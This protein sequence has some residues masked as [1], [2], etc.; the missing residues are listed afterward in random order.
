VASVCGHH[1]PAV[2]GHAQHFERLRDRVEQPG[3]RYP[4]APVDRQLRR[5]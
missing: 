1:G 2:V 3:V 5:L 4:L